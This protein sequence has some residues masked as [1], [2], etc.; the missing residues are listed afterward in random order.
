MTQR[1][2]PKTQRIKPKTQRTEHSSVMLSCGSGFDPGWRT[3]ELS[4]SQPARQRAHVLAAESQPKRAVSHRE[5]NSEILVVGFNKC[6]SATATVRVPAAH[7]GR[8]R[9]VAVR[10]C[11]SA[12]SGGG[13]FA[14]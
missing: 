9:R 2:N 3:N 7:K 11:R 4:T 5:T 8:S 13:Y 10:C 12:T 14:R 1:I 6:E